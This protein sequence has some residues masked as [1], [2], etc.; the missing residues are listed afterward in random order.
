MATVSQALT[1]AIPGLWRKKSNDMSQ[2][3]AGLGMAPINIMRSNG[4]YQ[5]LTSDLRFDERD[6][7]QNKAAGDAESYAA[8]DIQYSS[9]AVSTQR[10][11][12]KMYI[13][14][15]RVALAL[16]SDNE[17][18]DLARDAMDAVSNQLLDGWNKKFTDAAIAGLTAGS[19]ALD[20][21]SPSAT[22]LVDYFNTEVE[23][24]QLTSGKRPNRLLIS[25]QV[26]HALR[27]MDTVQGATAL[28]GADGGGGS[29]FRRTGY[30]GF[31]AVQEFFRAMYGLEVLVDDRTY[32]DSSGTARY[33]FYDDGTSTNYAFLGFADPR[34][35]AITTFSQKRDI[36]DYDVQDLVLPNPRGVG[37][38]GDARY[39]V[40]VTDPNAGRLL[41]V[42]L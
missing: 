36:I 31:A 37:V 32:I 2:L 14:P 8:G 17:V 21:S 33:A 10:Y 9:V 16:E 22:D 15:E 26:A 25:S 35:G 24:I 39:K 7:E 27:N 12:S 1:K 42:T 29:T 23:N 13:I 18:M 20:L 4:E 34:S 41:T 40:E 5:I 19:G 3:P 11:I 28:G 38:V 6:P 30:A